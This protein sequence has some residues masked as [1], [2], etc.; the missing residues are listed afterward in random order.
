MSADH[1]CLG[2]LAGICYSIPDRLAKCDKKIRGG[3]LSIWRILEI[4]LGIALGIPLANIVERI[5]KAL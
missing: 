1:S 3:N 5:F 4:A 2:H